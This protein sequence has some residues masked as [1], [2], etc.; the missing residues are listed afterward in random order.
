[1]V[2]EILAL[3]ARGRL[4]S[5][6]TEGAQ[7]EGQMERSGYDISI[8]VTKAVESELGGTGGPFHLARVVHYCYMPEH[9]IK[10]NIRIPRQI[11]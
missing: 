8:S 10:R 2:N 7:H 3:L 6:G 4:R 5:H 11:F 1:M 9:G